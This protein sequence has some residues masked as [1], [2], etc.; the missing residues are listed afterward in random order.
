MDFIYTEEFQNYYLAIFHVDDIP[1]SA[2]VDKETKTVIDI[3]TLTS[4]VYNNGYHPYNKDTSL[5]EI[6]WLSVSYFE[7]EEALVG[8]FNNEGTR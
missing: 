4:G 8:Y 7:V 6:D 3:S 1:F 5:K 2:M